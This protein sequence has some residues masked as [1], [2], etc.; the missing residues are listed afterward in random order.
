MERRWSGLHRRKNLHSKQQE[1]YGG[2]SKRESQLGRCRISRTT[3]DARA[4]Q[5]NLLVA[6]T[7]ER[8]QE[9]RREIL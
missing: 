4:T 9:I 7:K 6:K 3:Q 8:Y 5:E 2:N 1:D